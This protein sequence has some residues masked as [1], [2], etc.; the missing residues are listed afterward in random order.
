MTP[1]DVSSPN[2]LLPAL[3]HHLPVLQILLPMMGA[4]IIVLLG[5]RLAWALS[6]LLA[7]GALAIA[8]GLLSLASGG[9]P[10][11][12]ELH[13]LEVKVALKKG[14]VETLYHQEGKVIDQITELNRSIYFETSWMQKNF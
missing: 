6:C 2:S 9:T 10:L 3:I 7:G 14:Q 8:L 11:Q 4:P 1:H 13:L 5:R 12:Y